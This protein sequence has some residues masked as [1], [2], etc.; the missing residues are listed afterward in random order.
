MAAPLAL[1]SSSPRRKELLEK[2]GFAVRVVPAA[3]D[4]SQLPGELPE[5]YAKRVA[6]TKVLAAVKRLQA[7]LYTSDQEARRHL[8]QGAIGMPAGT[9]TRGDEPVRWVVG[10]DTVV[11]VDDVIFGKPADPQEAREMLT[12][13]SGREH[14]VMSGF[15]LFDLRRNREGLQAV[16]TVVKFKDLTRAEIDQYVS[17]GESMDKAGAYAVQGVGSYLVE[18]LHGSYT[19]VVGLPLCQVIEMMEEMGARDVLPWGGREPLP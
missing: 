18:Y 11:V 17:A 10:A 8:H 9:L 4:E 13:L 2:L 12:R 14:L 6:R 7:T 19:N 16:T 15:C 1:A 5:D 3:V